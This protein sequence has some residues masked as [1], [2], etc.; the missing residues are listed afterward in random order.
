MKADT[1]IVLKM[2]V[3]LEKVSPQTIQVNINADL[4]IEGCA[5]ANRLKSHKPVIISTGLSHFVFFLFFNGF[6]SR[7]SNQ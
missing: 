7:A 4:R 2:D 6:K 5:P 1:A 3:F